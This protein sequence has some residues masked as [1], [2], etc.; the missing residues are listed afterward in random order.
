MENKIIQ[1]STV[2]GTI[3][4]PASKSVMQRAIAIAALAKGTS[5]LYGYSS[6]NDSD[7]ALK[8]AENLGATVSVDGE[9][10]TI[11]GGLKPNKLTLNCGEAGLGIRMF[12]PIASLWHEPITLQGEG[13]LKKRPVNVL[14]DPLRQLGVQISTS[15]G[16]VP[17]Q[18][19]GPMIGGY[20]NVDGSLSSQILTGLLIASPYAQKDVILNVKDLKSKPYIDIT[21]DMMQKFG[22]SV[23]RHDYDSFVIPAEQSYKAQDFTIEG[24]WSGAAFLLVA[25]ALNGSITVENISMDSCQAD[26]AI[27]DVLKMIGANISINK[28][29]ISVSRKDLNAF[30]FDATEC[31]DLFPPLVSLAAHCDGKSIIKG[32]SR[33]AHKESNRALVLQTEFAKLGTKIDLNGDE[34]IVY[35]GTVNGGKMHANNDHRIAMAG[36]VTA[37]LSPNPIEV[38]NP[39]C[40]AKSYPN[41]WEDLEKMQGK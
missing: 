22:V 33:L 2:S 20:A 19:C 39:E 36:A 31:P 9:N 6:S 34:M 40:V 13:S 38:E 37:L 32:V 18:V 8:I 27:M 41:F 11:D 15:N 4:P 5:H 17:V 1:P 7:A 10:V 35:G 21:L 28:N 16:F 23:G 14:E 24:D 25:G 29:S 26:K 3:I 30:S 12:T